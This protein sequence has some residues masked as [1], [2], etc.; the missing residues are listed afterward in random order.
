MNRTYLF[1][2]IGAA[3]LLIA[4]LRAIEQPHV[5]PAVRD[6]P[7]VAAV[8]A[9]QVG[10]STSTVDL[11]TSSE[12]RTP[13]AGAPAP[14]NDPCAAV[15]E[16]LQ[17]ANARDAE[18]AIAIATLRQDIA[19]LALELDRLRFDESTPY[20]AFLR[21]DEALKINDPR[22]LVSIQDW[23]RQFPIFLGQ[24]E[25]TWIAERVAA[26]DWTLFG[27][28]SEVALIQFLGARRLA[29]ELPPSRAAEL[30]MYYADEP[31]V[32]P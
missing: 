29:A 17:A 24:G 10:A 6:T 32:F 13:A 3:A 27:R 28:T 4:L 9:E 22:A 1:T 31:G 15:L 16:Q 25:A 18:S 5:L 14:E 2:G 19:R 30:R 8:P 7:L 26:N 21:S 11:W 23:L 12:E 20:G